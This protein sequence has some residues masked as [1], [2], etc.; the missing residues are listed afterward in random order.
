MPW[1]VGGFNFTLFLRTNSFL[2]ALSLSVRRFIPSYKKNT[3]LSIV[4][5]TSSGLSPGATS[6]SKVYL[7]A[8]GTHSRLPTQSFSYDLPN[9]TQCHI[10]SMHRILWVQVLCLAPVQLLF[11]GQVDIE[12]LFQFQLHPTVQ[13]QATGAGQSKQSTPQNLCPLFLP[14]SS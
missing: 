6:T 12:C 13:I 7:S 2:L 5:I 9:L 8:S 10:Q 1:L 3:K 4:R 14:W 11:H